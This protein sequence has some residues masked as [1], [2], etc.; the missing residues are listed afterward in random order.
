MMAKWTL[1]GVNYLQ[2]LLT[3]MRFTLAVAY[4]ALK[5]SC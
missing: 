3:L 1:Q 5:I 2:A 4:M